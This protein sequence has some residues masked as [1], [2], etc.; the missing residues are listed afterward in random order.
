MKYANVFASV[1]GISLLAA[2]GSAGTKEAPKTADKPA[3]APKVEQPKEL[4]FYN[5]SNSNATL[6]AFL[7]SD[8]GKEIKAKYPD[9]SIK[10]L[11][12]GKGLEPQDII[13]SGHP[14]DIIINS[15]FSYPV[16]VETKLISDISD[17]IKKYGYDLN[18]IEPAFIDSQRLLENGKVYGLP[19]ANAGVALF[20]NKDIFD[21]FGVAY[22]KDGMTW[23]QTYDLAKKLTRTDGGVQYY[24]FAT[25]YPFMY[26]VN[27]L[28]LSY[29]N[30]QTNKITVNNDLFKTF[31]ENFA[32]FEQIP[33]NEKV[34]TDV[35]NKEKRVA[36][37]AY[38]SGK[39]DF[40]SWDMVSMPSFKDAP[41]VGPQGYG[42][43]MNIA[44][45]SKN[46]DFAFEV[47]AH[48][49]SDA[50][51]KK[52]AQG[53]SIPVVRTPDVVKAFDQ[54]A[55]RFKGKNVKAFFPDKRPTPSFVTKYD[56]AIAKHM[57]NAY[58]DVAAGK[59]DVNTALRD[60]E[61]AATKEIASMKQ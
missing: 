8:Q 26:N 40:D 15:V 25:R 45:T 16:L 11:A 29:Y 59:K 41:G 60:A 54:D 39:W 37:M 21:K 28:S 46:K 27:Q 18:R 50:V 51:Q 2:C 33:G 32:R 3:A 19:T 23:D 1:I 38:Q 31:I 10:L 53:G 17:L 43:Y 4:V 57:N 35:F 34:N 22:P 42:T 55:G 13:A 47:L 48:L 36:M 58:A 61:E 20:Y 14:I 30:L 52:F 5:A 9:L 12:T 44:A 6:E 24:G 7:D 49:S 56:N